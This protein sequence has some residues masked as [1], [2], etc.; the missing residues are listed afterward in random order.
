M[1]LL[2]SDHCTETVSEILLL[3]FEFCEFIYPGY[4]GDVSLVVREL[5]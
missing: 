4:E 1:H 2:R 5:F 3:I